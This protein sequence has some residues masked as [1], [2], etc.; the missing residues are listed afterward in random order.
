MATDATSTSEA[1]APRRADEHPSYVAPGQ[2]FRTVTD[3]ISS[4]VLTRPTSPGWLI[5]FLFS[6]ALLSLFTYVVIY[7]LAYGVGIWGINIPVAWAFAIILH[8]IIS[9]TT[10]RPTAQESGLAA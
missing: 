1:P 9:R 4:I 7:L 8:P 3:K 6:L 10:A 5:L 2:S